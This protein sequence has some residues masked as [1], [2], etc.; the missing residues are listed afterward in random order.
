LYTLEGGVHAYLRWQGD[1]PLPADAQEERR[2]PLWNGS[3]FVF[4]NRLAVP[5]PG[6]SHSSRGRIG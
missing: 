2:D 6:A 5:P 3:L 4:D 1:G